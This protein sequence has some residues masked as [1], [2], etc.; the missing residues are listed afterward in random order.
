MR[1]SINFNFKS[2]IMA[3]IWKTYACPDVQEKID[4]LKAYGRDRIA[5]EVEKQIFL[6]IMKWGA[7]YHIDKQLD[8][9]LD[10][11]KRSNFIW[12]YP[13]NEDHTEVEEGSDLKMD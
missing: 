9:E 11:V 1:C 10:R 3:Y 12:V 2:Q 7:L 13:S 4:K 8:E 5:Q 6:T